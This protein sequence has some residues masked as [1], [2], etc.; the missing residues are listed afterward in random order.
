MSFHKGFEDTAGS[1]TAYAVFTRVSITPAV[2]TVQPAGS[3]SA[4]SNVAALRSSEGSVLYGY[5]T[6]PF[7]FT[8]RTK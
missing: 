8:L 1:P 3:C 6:V 4:A 2:W 7:L 5:Y